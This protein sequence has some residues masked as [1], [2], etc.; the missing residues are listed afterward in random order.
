MFTIIREFP[1]RRNVTA[2][3]SVEKMAFIK[4]VKS[5]KAA[6]GYDPY[7]MTHQ[8]AMLM[9]TPTGGDRNAAHGGPA[10]TPW[11]REFLNRLEKDLR[12][13]EPTTAIPYWDWASDAASDPEG[14]EVWSDELMGGDG[15]RHDSSIVKTGPF[16]EGEWITI[17]GAGASAGPLER[18]FKGMDGMTF[19]PTQAD[20]EETLAVKFYDSSPW[21]AMSSPSFRNYLEGW[22]GPN[23]HNRVHWWVGGSMRF[24][25][26]PNDPVFF[27]HHCFVDK[28]WAEWQARRLENSTEGEDL[29]A[30]YEPKSG[31]PVGHNVSDG[32]YPWNTLEDTVTPADVLNHRQYY[33]Y[34]TDP[35]RIENKTSSLTF[36]GIPEDEIA[37]RA[38]V[39]EV[40]TCTRLTLEITGG[41]FAPFSA[42][43]NSVVVDPGRESVLGEARLWISYT[44]TEDGEDAAGSITI[45]A[46]ETKN[47]W[48][49]PISAD[50]KARPT[51]AIVLALDKSGSM[52]SPSG[53]SGKKRIDVLQES[54]EPFAELL[55]EGHGLG[56]ISFN[57]N[58]YDV[59]PVTKLGDLSDPNRAAVSSH[60]QNHSMNLEGLTAIGSALEKAHQLLSTQ[61]N[62]D[63]KATIVLTDGR[64]TASKYIREVSE[65]IN[66]RVYAIGL[67]T[68]DQIQPSA[69]TA[70]TNNTGGYVYLTGELNDDLYFRLTKYYLQVLAGITNEEIVVDPQ[71]WHRPGSVRRVPFILSETD[72]SCDVILLSPAPSAFDFWLE[73]PQGD[74]IDA[75]VAARLPAATFFSGK[76]S[77]FY[78]ANL[79]MP[80]GSAG[81]AREGV[82]NAVMEINE[83]HF[84]KYLE[85]LRD[86][87]EE[88]RK[89]KAHGIR[90]SVNVHSYSNLRMRACL[91]QDSNEPGANMHLRVLMS[92]YGL[93]MPARVRVEVQLTRPDTTTV[94]L[95]LSETEPGV[96]MASF[97]AL[98]PGVYTARILASGRT[99]QGRNFTREHTLTGSVWQGGDRPV[100]PSRSD[101]NK[102]NHLYDL[103]SCL[104]GDPETLEFL[105]KREIP[106]ESLQ[107]CITHMRTKMP[108]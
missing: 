70:L 26:S 89:A 64:E 57:D 39:F 81:G 10:F 69:L 99:F 96:F 79:P 18:M 54:V 68:A 77:A 74:R 93:P 41:L 103:L 35:P 50:T 71:G 107:K 23:L 108:R 105:K 62:Y 16:Q 94:T 32:M 36:E 34:D 33:L 95:S 53:I 49:I 42:F 52:N 20:I 80:I 30:Q 86:K 63:V 5:L 82:W 76:H 97:S 38:V 27:L 98:L 37:Y 9:V 1:C 22:K 87:S 88:L 8:Q 101:E 40:E 104:L 59:M 72:I 46:V 24:G 13:I 44:G 29:A 75:T 45:R 106:V 21:N 60:L 90:F 55:Q 11:H 78:R 100:P 102:D 51:A 73:T 25:T 67:G 28:I 17:D 15:D 6:G 66:E 3:S 7:V 14:G 84:K 83:D 43:Q 91:T 58:T 85:S 4:A 47:E 12:M 92:E 19:L 48:T 56:I 61:T 65:F 31:G 2:L